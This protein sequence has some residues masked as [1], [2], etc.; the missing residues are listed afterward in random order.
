MRGPPTW[1]S[2]LTADRFILFEFP[3]CLHLAR[4][5]E[6]VDEVRPTKSV[7]FTGSGA[8][9]EEK[10][11]AWAAEMADL[12]TELVGKRGTTLG[13][14]RMNANVAVGLR[15]HGL[16]IVDAQKAIEMA[17]TVKSPEK[18]KRITASLQA[19][20]V[21][22]GNFRDAVRPG[23]TK[24][25]LWSV[26]HESV[27]EQN[28]DHV[29]T[30]L[31]SAG[32]RTNPWFQESVSYVIKENELVALDTGVVGCHGFYSD[33][34]RTFHTGPGPPSDEHRELYKA[35]YEQMHH[36][37]GI[38]KPGLTFREYAEQAW[39]IP[40]QYW[41]SRYFLSAHRC[42]LTGEYPYLYHR[43]EFPNAG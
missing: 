30:H 13:L 43:G 10:E 41:A 26:M 37:M 8:L 24:N 28:Y 42:G 40:E 18:M 7:T 6:A 2:V 9:D 21:A 31:L 5:Y 16:N 1:Y 4:G 35:A 22:V 36:N 33:V 14:E 20:E 3:G 32:P 29:E 39:D 38:L 34:S 19:I 27:I 12:I 17:R 11:R 15:D 23:L 25:E